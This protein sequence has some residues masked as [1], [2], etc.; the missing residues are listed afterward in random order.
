MEE[1][2]ETRQRS[3]HKE[4]EREASGEKESG[5]EEEKETTAVEMCWIHLERHV[6]VHTFISIV[7]VLQRS[8]VTDCQS[9]ACT[10]KMLFG[11]NNA[12]ALTSFERVRAD[13]FESS[14]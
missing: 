1:I 4:R 2:M 10:K 13:T 11:C 5:Q 7:V 6:S 8:A 3:S 14:D 12:H 9:A